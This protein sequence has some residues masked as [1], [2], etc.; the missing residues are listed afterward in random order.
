MNY[1]TSISTEVSLSKVLDEMLLDGTDM[2]IVLTF[3]KSHEGQIGDIYK[4]SAFAYDLYDL[5]AHPYRVNDFLVKHVDDLPVVDMCFAAESLGN[6]LSSEDI[7]PEVMKDL[8]ELFR[9]NANIINFRAV[10]YKGGISDDEMVASGELDFFKLVEAITM[11]KRDASIFLQESYLARSMLMA[12]NF[13]KF[14]PRA[15]FTILSAVGDSLSL[16]FRRHCCHDYLS[17]ATNTL[18]KQL[19]VDGDTEMFNW[20]VNVLNLSKPPKQSI[21]ETLWV[22]QFERIPSSLGERFGR[23]LRSFEEVVFE[24]NMMETQFDVL[25]LFIYIYLF[26]ADFFKGMK[27]TTELLEFFNLPFD[28]NEL[29][30][31]RP[32]LKGI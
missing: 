15:Q 28:W 3:L 10:G 18:F 29:E 19:L 6:F 27:E 12:T 31:L 26:D 14:S 8:R 7:Y 21:V 25:D 11:D 17:H 5:A 13:R 23:E 2:E 20:V 22:N 1:D 24:M 32:D 30:K 9:G 4:H 16:P